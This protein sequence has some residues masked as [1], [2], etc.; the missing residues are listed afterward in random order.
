MHARLFHLAF[1]QGENQVLAVPL[2]VSAHGGCALP[3]PV[4]RPGRRLR[5]PALQKRVVVHGSARDLAAS[6]C[7]YLQADSASWLGPTR[8]LLPSPPLLPMQV[9]L[10]AGHHQISVW[11]GKQ[12]RPGSVPL[13]LP[14]DH[15]HNGWLLRRGQLHTCQRQCVS[16]PP[17]APPLLLLLPLPGCL[18]LAG[19]SKK[20]R[21]PAQ[22]PLPHSA[23]A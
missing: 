21:A 17:A 18:P 5:C 8:I 14:T 1:L 2:L 10:P 11:G 12:R 6:V 3:L 4:A 19:A 16:G 7:K 23:C 22:R 9:H 15:K 13:Q 20:A